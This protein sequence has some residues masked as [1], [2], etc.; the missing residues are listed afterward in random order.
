MATPC[1]DKHD[2]L[3]LKL[4]SS[5]Y[6]DHDCG[7]PSNPDG[8]RRFCCKHCPAQGAP[9]LPKMEWAGNPA[10]LQH[11]PPEIAAACVKLAADAGVDY[12]G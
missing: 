3:D 10:L 2:R 6:L 9:L 5:D 11:L 7:S 12:F 8:E 1:C 4:S